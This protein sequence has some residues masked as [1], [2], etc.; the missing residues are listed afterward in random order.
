MVIVQPKHISYA[1]ALEST[2]S[3]FIGVRAINLT[4]LDEIPIIFTQK[5]APLCMFPSSASEHVD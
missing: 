5:H 4:N 2:N 1:L 3:D